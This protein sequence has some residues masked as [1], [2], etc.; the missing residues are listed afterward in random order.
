[1]AQ[2]TGGQSIVRTLMDH[3]VDVI[4]GLP[5]VPPARRKST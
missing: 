4:F 1:M 3:D 2:M 5:G